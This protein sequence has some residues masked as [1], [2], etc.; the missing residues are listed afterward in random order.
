MWDDD[1]LFVF[2]L[3]GGVD[4][5]IMMEDVVIFVIEFEVLGNI[6]LIEVYFKVLYVFIV[7]GLNCY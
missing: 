4:I 2:V 1:E 6:Y 3:Y 5:F 7:F